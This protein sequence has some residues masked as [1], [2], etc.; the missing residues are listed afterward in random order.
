MTIATPLS[1][2]WESAMHIDRSAIGPLGLGGYIVPSS[3]DSTGYI[4]HVELDSAGQRVCRSV[5]ARSSLSSCCTGA[6]QFGGNSWLRRRI[7][8][9]S[10]SIA[11]ANSPPQGSSPEIRARRNETRP[12]CAGCLQHACPRGIL[13][14]AVVF[15]LPSVP[16]S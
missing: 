8:G 14:L 16:G 3:R 9:F 11:M 12:C 2:R 13:C 6:I 5:P 7:V 15:V 4:V 10:R 1:L